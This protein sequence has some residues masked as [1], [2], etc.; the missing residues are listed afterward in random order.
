MSNF[1]PIKSKKI[2]FPTNKFE[3]YM[4][5]HTF[6]HHMITLT[7]ENYVKKVKQKAPSAG[8]VIGHPKT[9]WIFFLQK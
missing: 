8:G 7:N 6:S 3:Y 1:Q 5:G 9:E 2:G 4:T